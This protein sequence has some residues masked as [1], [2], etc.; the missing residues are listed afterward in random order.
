MSCSVQKQVAI[1]AIQKIPAVVAC[2]KSLSDM[3]K[4]PFPT[5]KSCLPVHEEE[6]RDG[7]GSKYWLRIKLVC[8]APM[9]HIIL[10]REDSRQMSSRQNICSARFTADLSIAYS[11]FGG[12]ITRRHQLSILHK[13]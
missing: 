2:S 5:H 13:L 3:K 10:Y 6:A 7:Y 9:H 8:A 4:Y 11:D 1:A 12:T